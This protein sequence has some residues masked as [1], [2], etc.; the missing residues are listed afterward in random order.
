MYPIMYSCDQNILK[1][2]KT[3]GLVHEIDQGSF[4]LSFPSH[5]T[6]MT[7]LEKTIV[8]FIVFSTGGAANCLLDR[9]IPVNQHANRKC[10]V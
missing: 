6:G 3:V 8:C 7:T 9:I 5:M 10:L 2:M 4:E 1:E